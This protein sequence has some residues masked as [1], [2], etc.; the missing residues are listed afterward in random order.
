MKNLP[1]FFVIILLVGCSNAPSEEKETT[2]VSNEGIAMNKDSLKGIYE[3]LM[4]RNDYFSPSQIYELGKLNP[5]DEAQKDTIFFVFRETLRQKIQEKDIFYLLD[6]IDPSIKSGHGDEGG[7]QTFTS[8]WGLES[9]ESTQESR[10]WGILDE[11]LARGGAF[12]NKQK[13]FV[14]NYVAATFPD[15]KYDPIAHAVVVGQGVRM[16]SAPSLNS[17]VNGRCSYDIVK[18][19]DRSGPT[20]TIGG[21]TYPWVQIEKTDG[22]MGYIFGK[23]IVAPIDFRAVFQKNN[24]QWKMTALTAGD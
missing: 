23:Y 7:L 20:Q 1:L 22:A 10:L 21:E 24:N 2:T 17:E 5:V 15:E 18:V 11:V 13:T 6:I 9:E 16:R 8:V 4:N 14:A 12:S 3:V 19:L